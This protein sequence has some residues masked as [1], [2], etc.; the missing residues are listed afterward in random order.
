M[1]ITLIMVLIPA[2]IK[3]LKDHVW[4]ISITLELVRNADYWLVSD[5]LYQKGG[6]R[7]GAAICVFKKAARTLKHFKVWELLLY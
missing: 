6:W 2:L 5:L 4:S 1:F 3:V 7:E